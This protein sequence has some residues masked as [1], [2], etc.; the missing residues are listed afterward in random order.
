MNAKR[1]GL[2]QPSGAFPWCA[3]A[4]RFNLEWT[5]GGSGRNVGRVTGISGGEIREA[6]RRIA[7][8]LRF[9]FN[10]M[11]TAWSNFEQDFLNANSWSQRK[12]GFPA[13]LL[14]ALS[15]EERNQAIAILRQKLDGRDDWPVRAMAHLQ[16]KDTVPNLQTLLR[17]ERYPVMRA[18]IATAI[19]ELTGDAEMEREVASV[20]A[21][22]DKEWVHRLDAIHC[23]GRFKTDSA[24]K[25]LN[26]LTHD[27]DYLVSYNAKIAGGRSNPT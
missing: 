26:K 14:D 19:Y 27:S 12:D 1:L 10:H 17:Q 13:D 7:V 9:N 11:S 21:A 22:C 25:L 16:V 24:Q 6:G 4:A 3:K 2:R 18:V 5:T 23:L 20:A 8:G 15:L